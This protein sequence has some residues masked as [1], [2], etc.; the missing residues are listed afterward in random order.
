MAY[1]YRDAAPGGTGLGRGDPW[2]GQLEGP[3]FGP[4][5][6]A[7]TDGVAEQL[8]DGAGEEGHRVVLGGRH[9]VGQREPDRCLPAAAPRPVGFDASDSLI[10]HS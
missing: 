9:E 8:G 5:G 7:L 6:E 1:A 3:G 10:T 2:A 4:G